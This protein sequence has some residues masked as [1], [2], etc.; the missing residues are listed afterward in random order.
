MACQLEFSM[1]IIVRKVI[2]SIIIKAAGDYIDILIQCKIIGNM[3][4]GVNTHTFYVSQG[5]N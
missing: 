1:D 5:L 4:V 3:Y 2:H